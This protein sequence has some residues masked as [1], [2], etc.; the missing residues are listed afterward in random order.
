MIDYK[1]SYTSGEQSLTE[2]QVDKLLGS[3]SSMRDRVLLELTLDT[4]MRRSDV[5]RLRWDWFNLDEGFVVFPEKKKGDS[6]HKA[7]LRSE[8]CQLLNM[9][10][11]HED[12]NSIYVFNGRCNKKYGKGHI[13]GRTCYNVLQRCCE[14]AGVNG[15]PFHALRAT[16]IKLMQKRGVPIEACAKQ[17]NDRVE[18][19]QKHYNTPSDQEMK[20]LF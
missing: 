4:G 14:D 5:C 11:G 18:T 1:Q 10:K 12:T 19:I 3:C 20:E 17:V 8:T 7:Y 15:V 2:K 6:P 9:F 13:S 16:S